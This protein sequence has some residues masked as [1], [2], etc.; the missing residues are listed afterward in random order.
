GR[1]S[2]ETLHLMAEAMRR[3]YCDRARYLGD[4]DF[5]KIPAFLT[6]KEYARKLAAGIDRNKATPSADL[7][8]DI[9]LARE[10]D[11]T[12]HFSV[13]DRDGMAVSNTYTLERSY[14]S[15]VVVRGAGFV[16]NNEMIDFNWFPGVT[17][18]HGTIGTPANQIAPGKR[19]LS[20]Q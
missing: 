17:T 6:T 3:A 2:P 16:L 19:M 14:G 18:R 11:N 5:V 13:I 7:A 1:W 9:P 20:S 4:A 8:R 10:G 12:T 15:R